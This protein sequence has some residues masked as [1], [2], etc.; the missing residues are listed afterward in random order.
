MSSG[1]HTLEDSVGCRKRIRVI[2]LKVDTLLKVLRIGK[3]DVVKIDVE[4]HEDKV[5][6]GMKRLLNYNP[7]RVLVIETR[8]DNLSLR[9][10]IIEKGYRVQVLDCWNS[11]CNYG[12]YIVR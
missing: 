9:E 7:P 11:T 1:A 5:I 6:N 2:T 3:V 10:L 8:R 4:G 12:F